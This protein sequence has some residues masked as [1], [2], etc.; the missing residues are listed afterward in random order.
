MEEKKTYRIVQYWQGIMTELTKEIY[1]KQE[2]DE[3]KQELER[4]K[5]DGIFDL[6]IV[7]E[8]Q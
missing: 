3:M 1:S 7:E 2:Y 5:Y 8:I 6:Y 4:L